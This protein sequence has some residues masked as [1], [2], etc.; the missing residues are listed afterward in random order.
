MIKETYDFYSPFNFK[1][2]ELNPKIQYQ[3]DLLASHDLL[4]RQHSD[5]V[6]NLVYRIC[7]YLHCNSRVYSLLHYL[8]ISSRYWKIIYSS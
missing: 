1:L 7:E 4:T 6:A 2:R 8:R 5:N 3:L